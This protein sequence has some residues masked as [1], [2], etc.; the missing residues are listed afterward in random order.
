MPQY[1][2]IGDTVNHSLLKMDL[3]S[4]EKPSSS[5]HQKGRWSLVLCTSHTKA[6]PKHSCLPMVDLDMNIWMSVEVI[7]PQGLVV[8]G[9]PQ[10]VWALV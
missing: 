2:S 7:P 4:V 5:L 10:W 8:M 3:C 9:M 6:S 1:I